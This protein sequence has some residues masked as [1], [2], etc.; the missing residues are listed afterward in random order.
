MT[1]RIV[2]LIPW[3]GAWPEWIDFF[4]ESC[5]A[6]SKIDW[7]IFGDSDP[8]QNRSRNVRHVA[9]TF[10][11]YKELVSEAVGVRLAADEPYKLCDIRPALPLVHSDLTQGYDFVGTGD[12]DVIYGDIRKFYD[13]ETLDRYD[14][15]SSHSGRVSGHFC[16]MRN[17]EEMITAFKR[18]RDWK[19]ACR[20]TEYLNFDERGFFNMLRGRQRRSVLARP[21]TF[22]CLFREAY[23]TPGVTKDMRWFWKDGQ[24]TNEFYP[25]HPFMYLHFMSWHSNRWFG[26]QPGV[27]AGTPAPWARLDRIVQIDWRLAAKEGFMISPAGIQP[28]DRSSYP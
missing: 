15:L 10:E 16:L 5:R 12:L 6:N 17:S 28:I 3:F 27:A 4:V 11:D 18:A 13:S 20:S 2:V 24:L 25:H 9:S 23:S 19:K 8:P 21:K 22:A 26:H 1:H 7:I 14:L